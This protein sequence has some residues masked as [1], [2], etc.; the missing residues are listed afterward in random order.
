MVNWFADTTYFIP[1][2]SLM[3]GP[4]DPEIQKFLIYFKLGNSLSD[5]WIIQNENQN[6][7]KYFL[8][9]DPFLID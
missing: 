9:N 6:P 3:C 4:R 2:D 8:Q 7:L 5:C 1:F